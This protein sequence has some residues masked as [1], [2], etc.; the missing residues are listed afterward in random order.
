MMWMCSEGHLAI[1]YDER[2]CPVCELKEEKDDLEKE[3]EK[4]T[5]KISRLEDEAVSRTDK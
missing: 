3:V 4:L 1:V 5:E 2:S